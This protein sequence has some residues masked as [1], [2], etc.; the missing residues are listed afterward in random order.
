MRSLAFAAAL[1]FSLPAFADVAPPNARRLGYTYEVANLAAHP[2]A[3]VVAWPRACGSDGRS[4]GHVDLAL[5]PHLKD[6]MH[7]VDYEVVVAG[8]RHGIGKFCATSTALYA[9]PAKDYPTQ[10]R[11]FEK[12]DWMLGLKKGDTQLLIPALNAKSQAERIPFFEEEQQSQRAGHRFAVVTWVAAP[13]PLKAIHDVLEIATLTSRQFVVK[14]ARVVYAYDDG[15]EETLSYADGVRPAPSRKGALRSLSGDTAVEPANSA[16]PSATTSAGTTRAAPSASSPSAR[17]GERTE[18][19]DR[20]SRHPQ[21]KAHQSDGDRS[22]RG[23]RSAGCGLAGGQDQ[24]R[25]PSG[26]IAE[27]V[28][29][30]GERRLRRLWLGSARGAPF[31]KAGGAALPARANQ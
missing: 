20:V 29:C 1:C 4:L 19:D 25:A 28:R 18:L 15:K 21:T 6:R 2:Q 9:L 11:A 14:P 3:L 12:D 5:N 13:T 31:P 16:I 23:A 24:K 26:L 27:A 22:G 30:R 17:A 7:E 10:A 8:K